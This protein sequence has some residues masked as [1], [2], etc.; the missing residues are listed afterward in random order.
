M[1]V[2]EIT[3]CQLRLARQRADGG[4][5]PELQAQAGLIDVP[6]GAAQYDPPRATAIR[7]LNTAVPDRDRAVALCQIGTPVRATAV[8]RAVN[9]TRPLSVDGKTGWRWCDTS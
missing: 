1:A 2:E 8:D 7:T 9:R 4:G 6:V 3:S 5:K